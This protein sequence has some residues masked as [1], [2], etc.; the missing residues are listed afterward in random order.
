M[1]LR[2]Y[3]FAPPEDGA[4]LGILVGAFVLFALASLAAW[5]MSGRA[6]YAASRRRARQ[7]RSIALWAGIPGILYLL[8][9]QHDASFLELRIWLWLILAVFAGRLLL[10]SLR[11]RELAADK[12][13][14][15]QARR[16]KDYFKPRTRKSKRRERRR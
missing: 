7:L 15:R 5:V 4:Y 14:E 1:D 2:A 13:D 8:A 10:W 11:F 6:E 12:V 9:R 3:F 16:K